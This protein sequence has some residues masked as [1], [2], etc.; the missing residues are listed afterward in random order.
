MLSSLA[1]ILICFLCFRNSFF[2]FSCI[3]NKN[4][5]EKKFDKYFKKIKKEHTTSFSVEIS[6]IECTKLD[7][8]KGKMTVVQ[9]LY[10]KLKKFVITLSLDDG[11]MSL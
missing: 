9:G 1:V 11:T 5:T 2:V 8:K 4:E 10:L 6:R 7:K 3:I